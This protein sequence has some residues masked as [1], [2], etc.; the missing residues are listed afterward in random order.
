MRNK[1][2]EALRVAKEMLG[3]I[4]EIS[5]I[6]KDEI[7]AAIIS[8]EENLAEE[9][10]DK[11]HKESKKNGSE[12]DFDAY[13]ID[14]S[15]DFTCKVN[16]GGLFTSVA[17]ECNCSN[18]TTLYFLLANIILCA[19]DKIGIDAEGNFTKKKARFLA[20]VGA[21]ADALAKE[22]IADVAVDNKSEK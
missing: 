6:G 20:R 11:G 22:R 13:E 21:L 18:E 15:A 16:N 9:N 10:P 17:V 1:E 7:L 14:E 2:E 4:S 3:A 5:G 19:Y 8:S 12:E